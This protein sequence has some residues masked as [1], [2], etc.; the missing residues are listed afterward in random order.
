MSCDRL[1]RV[2]RIQPHLMILSPD[3]DPVYVE[4]VFEVLVAW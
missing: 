1:E 4:V 2:G 3:S